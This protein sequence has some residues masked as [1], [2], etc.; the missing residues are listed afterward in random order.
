MVFPG[1]WQLYLAEARD[2]WLCLGN[3]SALF[4][5]PFSPPFLHSLSREVLTIRSQ[6]VLGKILVCYLQASCKLFT[7]FGLVLIFLSQFPLFLLSWN[8]VTLQNNTKAKLGAGWEV[9]MGGPIAVASAV[10]C[11]ETASLKEAIRVTAGFPSS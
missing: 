11:R 3:K 2:C 5:F 6:S 7:M 9:V 4:S 1:S 10:D 8:P